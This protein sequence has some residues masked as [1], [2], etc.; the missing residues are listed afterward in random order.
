MEKLA[1]LPNNDS[2]GVKT[3]EIETN[4]ASGEVT[5]TKDIQSEQQHEASS[6]G[7]LSV[8][9]P[10]ANENKLP[11]VKLRSR[12]LVLLELLSKDT[13]F[14]KVIEDIKHVVQEAQDTLQPH[15][16][17]SV[18]EEIHSADVIC[19]TQAHLEDSVFSTEKETTA[20]E[21]MS[22]MVSVLEQV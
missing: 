8:L 10:G 15:A 17:N 1:C 4:E 9:S 22:S 16:G 5:T 3:S 20:K 19:D 11:L 18:F 6:N 12:I 13:D 21:T 2:N 7:D 14:G